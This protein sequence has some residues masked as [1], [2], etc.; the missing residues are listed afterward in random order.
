MLLYGNLQTMRTDKWATLKSTQL[1]T[2]LCV[3]LL[4]L[5]EN[6]VKLDFEALKLTENLNPL[7]GPI[8]TLTLSSINT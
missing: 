4:L 3:K 1:S 7:Q 8:H 5:F 6:A 2:K